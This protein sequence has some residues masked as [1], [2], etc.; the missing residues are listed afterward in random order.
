MLL[1]SLN[2]V[3]LILHFLHFSVLM[4]GLWGGCKVGIC[5]G[6]L[7]LKFTLKHILCRN[8]IGYRLEMTDVIDRLSFSKGLEKGRNGLAHY[9]LHR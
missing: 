3:T 4:P 5:L 7:R 1:L 9:L 6:P 2:F 8:R